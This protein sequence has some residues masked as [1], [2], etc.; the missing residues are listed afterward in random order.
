MNALFRPPVSAWVVPWREGTGRT[1]HIRTG[2]R[3]YTAD[4]YTVVVDDVLAAWLG[5]CD[6]GIDDPIEVV[7]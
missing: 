1:L 2:P 7:W 3:M 4:I 6:A 5:F